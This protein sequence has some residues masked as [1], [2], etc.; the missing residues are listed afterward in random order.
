MRDLARKLGRGL[1]GL[2]PTGR[3]FFYVTALAHVALKLMLGLRMALEDGY[4]MSSMVAPPQAA[5]FA[6]GDIL[7][8]FVVAR[9]LDA[10]PLRARRTTHLTLLLPLFGFLVA[11]FIVHGYFKAFVNRGLLEFNGAGALELTDYTVAGMNAYSVSFIAVVALMF[12]ALGTRYDAFA[13]SRLCLSMSPQLAV[14]AL[15]GAGLGYAGTLS[16]GQSGWLSYN[17]GYLLVLSYASAGANQVRVASADELRRFREPG[18]MGGHYDSALDIEV[19]AKPRANVL[20]LLIESLPLEQT[21]LGGKP[22]Q[23]PVL[24]ELAQSG[25][26]FDHFRTVFPATSRSFLTYHCGIYP[27]TGAATATKYAPHYQCDSVLDVLKGAGYRTGFFTAPMFTYDN[28]NKSRVMASY[29][30]YADFL[31]LRPTARK[32]NVAAPA[33]EEEAVVEALFRFLENGDSAP[34]FATYFLFWNHAPYRLPFKDISGLPAL[35]RYRLTLE[36]LNDII[37]GVLARAKAAGLLDNTIVIVTADH[38]EGFGIHHANTNHV[39]HLFEDDV[40]IPFLIHVPEI[41]RHVSARSASNVDF[42]PT[43]TRL[44]GLTAPKSWQGRDL[45]AKAFEPRPTLMFGR[46]SF[47]TNGLVDG[48]YKYIEYVDTEARYLFDVERDPEEQHDLLGSER[49]R[50]DR[51]QRLIHAWLPVVEARAWEASSRR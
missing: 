15:A 34:W 45:L 7:V 10:L 3:A 11:S 41:G 33:V 4:G 31:T 1:F 51:Y 22:D 42:A 27:T 39:G 36:Y 18:P 43:L 46:A 6:G 29:D 28:L 12:L 40:R 13:R 30:T 24:Q 35:D 2:S 8:C 44:L 23:L 50:A 26:S 16:S 38:G 14:L 37:S 32:N 17:P 21:S 5:V 49:A 25:V 20:F 19:P 48:S 9:G 47:T